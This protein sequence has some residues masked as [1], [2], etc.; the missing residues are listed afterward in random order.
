MDRQSPSRSESA[1]ERYSS[2]HRSR[3]W[4]FVDQQCFK[5]GIV[6]VACSTRDELFAHCSSQRRDHV[7]QHCLSKVG[8]HGVHR[9]RSSLP[10]VP[11]EALT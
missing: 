4:T 7:S 6:S 3:R 8:Q 9:L 10:F 1:H 5:R 11:S 2:E